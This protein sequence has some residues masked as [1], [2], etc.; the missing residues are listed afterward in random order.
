VYNRTM[1]APARETGPGGEAGGRRG[2]SG[3]SLRRVGG[4]PEPA[5]LLDLTLG[6]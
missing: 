5:A 3:A 6:P 1:G 4:N 2:G